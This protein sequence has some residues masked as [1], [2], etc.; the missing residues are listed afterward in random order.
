MTERILIHPGTPYN[1]PTVFAVDDGYDGRI[2]FLGWSRN[3]KNI[4]FYVLIGILW[5]TVKSCSSVILSFI[6]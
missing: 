1:F 4:N 2:V 3:P 5:S 6:I